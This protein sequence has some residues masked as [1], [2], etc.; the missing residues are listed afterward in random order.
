MLQHVS[1]QLIWDLI[2]ETRRELD[3]E[4]GEEKGKEMGKYTAYRGERETT[5][6]FL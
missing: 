6:Y 5:T 4:K 3:E 2:R 1:N